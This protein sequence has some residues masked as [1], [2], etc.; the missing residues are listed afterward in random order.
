MMKKKSLAVAMAA[1]TVAMPASQ[2]FAAVVESDNSEQ[3][4]AMK[5]KALELLN[6]KFTDNESL[7]INTRV[8]GEKVFKVQIEAKNSNEWYT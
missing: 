3:V 7:L 4:K 8:A 5:E 6:K 1:V 2:V